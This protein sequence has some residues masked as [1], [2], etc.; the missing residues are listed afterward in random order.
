MPINRG[1]L[2]LAKFIDAAGKCCV[3]LSKTRI[4]ARK[5]AVSQ[6]RRAR[7]P[8]KVHRKSWHALCNS[9]P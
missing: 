9:E 2:N 5:F 1:L 3:L 6:R 8:A 7:I 4:G